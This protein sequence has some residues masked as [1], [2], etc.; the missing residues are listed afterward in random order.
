MRFARFTFAAALLALLMTAA[1]A[2]AQ[3]LKIATANPAKIFTDLQETKDLQAKMVNDGKTLQAT[4][5]EKRQKLKD[6]Q[7]QR[8][9]LK[10]GSAQFNDIN[11][12]LMQASVDYEVWSKLEQN[13]IQREQKQQIRTLFEKITA[14]TADVA[15]QRGIDLVI[16]EQRPDFPDSMD[17]I[18][19]DQLRLLISQ[20]NV[21]YNSGALDI[22][23]DIIAAMDAKYKSGK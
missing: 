4:E 17:Q 22:S 20:R 19:P 11:K 15:K 10:E 1:S 13:E 7:A 14:T 18:T 21:L 23:N 8:D 12:Q 16:A 6:L 9:T 5:M 3:T 2:G